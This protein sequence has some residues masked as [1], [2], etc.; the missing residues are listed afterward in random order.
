MAYIRFLESDIMHEA[1]VIPDGNIVTLKF[2]DEK[3]ANNNGFDVFVD[4]DCEIDI[5]GEY[6]HEFTTIY[7][8]DEETD[9][10]NGYQLSNDGSIYAEPE[11]IQPEPQNMTLDELKKEKIAEMNQ[12]QQRIIQSGV[13]VLLSNGTTERFA[14]KDQDQ[15]SLMGLQT[16]AQQG[17]DRIPWHEANNAEHCKYYSAE[18]M[19][20]ITGAALSFISYQVT[21]FRDLRI[22]IDSMLDKDNVQSVFYGT[23]IPIEYQSEVLADFYSAQNA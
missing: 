22:Y 15:M 10:Y 13:D 16:L 2:Q 12:A 1:I 23:Y 8:N 5:G 14:L 7:R 19:S 3:E 20:R 18:D 9:K 21:Y 11:P 17:V 4:E 6:Y